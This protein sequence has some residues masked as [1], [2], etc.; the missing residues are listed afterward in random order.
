VDNSRWEVATYL[1][2]Y[3]T[4]THTYWT[5]TINQ[6]LQN[7]LMKYWTELT[8][9]INQCAGNRNQLKIHN[10]NLKT[11]LTTMSAT[12][13][14]R[15]S[16]LSVNDSA[17]LQPST[18]TQPANDSLYT[19]SCLEKNEMQNWLLKE[20]FFLSWT[21]EFFWLVTVAKSSSWAKHSRDQL[22]DQKTPIEDQY[23]IKNLLDQHLKT[24]LITR[25]TMTYTTR[26]ITHT[27]RGNNW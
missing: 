13:L 9:V 2:L 6:Y 8:H 26:T 19:E 4:H 16:I 10:T 21:S 17:I 23:Q 1:Y 18:N 12:S 20:W 5:L 24:K 14:S 7:M 22:I 27:H 15:L 3:H 11:L 25:S